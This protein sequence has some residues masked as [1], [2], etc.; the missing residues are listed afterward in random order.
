MNA[1]ELLAGSATDMAAAV[2]N[3][4]ISASTLVHTSLAR[5]CDTDKQVN[6]FTD[7]TA[8][9]ALQA[10][11]ALDARLAVGDTTVQTLPLLGVPF[12]V[13]N[14]FDVAGLTTLA[15]SKIERGQPAATHEGPLVARLQAAGAVLV[16]ALNMDE[17]AYGF[18]TENSHEGATHNPHDL[19]R[20]AGGSSGGS[21]AAVAAG[22]VPITLGS[23]T[24]GSIRVP[25]SL[26][27]TFGLKP[28]Y[29]RLPRNGTYPFVAS[30]D[31]LGP[32]ARSARDLAL[33]YDL[34]QGFDGH[35]PGCVSRPVEPTIDTL[36]LGI[37]GLRIATLGG[38][39]VDQ[40]GAEARA[41]V[42]RVSQ[43]LGVNRS[44]ELP[45]VARARAA[46]FIVSNAEGGAL[47]LPDLRT[48][49]ADFEPLS[50]D[51]FLAGALLPA[52][53]VQQAQRVRRWFA[54]RAAELFQEVDV[55]LAPAT[56]C[57]AT[58]LGAEWIEINGQRLPARPS[59]G[60]LTQPI[61][62]IGL[63]V[64]AVP[65][66]GCHP[67]LPIGVQVIAAPWRE[68]LVLRVAHRLQTMGVV[69]SPVAVLP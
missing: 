3:G 34:M 43:A 15:G 26:C 44:V 21:A 51:R 59:M 41:A 62:C 22:Q 49:A 57:A 31:H 60:L 1:K 45:E 9:R 65:V 27:G 23:D 17:Y 56:P 67:T 35:D 16:G 38:Y 29:G 25:S 36:D 2:R 47:H 6:A 32:F 61:S 54:L 4:S 19:A 68:D 42:A 46:A 24:N 55:L 30:L 69:A 40:A 14:L 11:S 53:W 5:I 8:Q 10:A 12:A 37:S 13:K 63:P 7:V 33:V 48:R 66:W 20:T 28:T 18:T 64:C 58:T 50:R 39:F 52:A